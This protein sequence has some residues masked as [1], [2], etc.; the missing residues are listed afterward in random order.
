MNMYR[1][2]AAE[3]ETH[4]AQ[5]VAG[6]PRKKSSEFKKSVDRGMTPGVYFK[7]SGGSYPGRQ[8]DVNPAC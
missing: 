5:G 2:T 6:T 7:V 1:G 4:T 8:G 3:P